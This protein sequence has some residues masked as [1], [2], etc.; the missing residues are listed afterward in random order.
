M[1]SAS[2]ESD[3]TSIAS[4]VVDDELLE[5]LA[6]IVHVVDAALHACGHPLA[7]GTPSVAEQAH[8][9]WATG[10]VKRLLWLLQLL[11]L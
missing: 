5:A 2:L 3:P 11:R 9:N 4:R 7:G 1:D 6:E 8:V 10:S